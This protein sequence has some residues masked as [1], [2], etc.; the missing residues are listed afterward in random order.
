MLKNDIVVNEFTE[1]I[2]VAIC[3]FCGTYSGMEL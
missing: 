3:A 1:R 2:Y